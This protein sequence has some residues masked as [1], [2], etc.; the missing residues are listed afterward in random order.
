MFNEF[1]VSILFGKASGLTIKGKYQQAKIAIDKCFELGIKEQE[2]LGH[3]IKG[4]IEC[5]LGNFPEAEKSLKMVIKDAEEN[6]NDWKSS[7]NIQILQ[8]VM[9]FWKKTQH[10]KT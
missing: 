2:I 6:P 10:E 9:H 4:E 3:A 1:R 7:H 8:R 5:E